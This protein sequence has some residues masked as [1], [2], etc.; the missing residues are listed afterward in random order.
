MRINLSK[1]EQ[2][3]WSTVF[4]LQALVILVGNVVA[5]RIFLKRKFLINKSCFLLINLTFADLIVGLSSTVIWFVAVAHHGGGQDHINLSRLLFLIPLASL[6]SLAVISIERAVAVFMP[7]RHRV[8]NNRHYFAAV[9]LCW[10]IFAVPSIL[11]PHIH[12]T[13]FKDVLYFLV[14]IFL[15]LILTASYVSIYVKMKFFPTLEQGRTRQCQFK[16]SKTLFLT[17]VASVIAWFPLPIVQCYTYFCDYHCKGDVLDICIMLTLVAQLSNSFLNLVVY[18]FRLPEFRKELKASLCRCF[19]RHRVH[20]IS[21][22]DA[23]CLDT[24]RALRTE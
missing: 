10:V 14:I 15:L 6:F 4:L 2:Y 22:A 21:R 3:I 11:G 17:T 1:Y 9:G 20:P 5:L 24:S 7:F 19:R 23:F 16:L 12:N 18:S 13:K 8:A